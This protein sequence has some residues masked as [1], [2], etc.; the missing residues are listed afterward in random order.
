MEREDGEQS[1]SINQDNRLKQNKRKFNNSMETTHNDRIEAVNADLFDPDK[2]DKERTEQQHLFLPSMNHLLL[3]LRENQ[4]NCFAVV[5]ELKFSF[6]NLSTETHNHIL[7][8]FGEFL[9]SS[10]LTEDK[11]KIAEQSQQA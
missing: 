8:D 1:C 4:L 3:M 11:E 6:P 10:D 5:A 7:L 9:S 2:I